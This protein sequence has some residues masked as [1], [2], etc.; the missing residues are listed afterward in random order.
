MDALTRRIH[1]D[2]ERAYFEVK[3]ILA[4]C[5]SQTKDEHLKA[6]FTELAKEA[7]K[8]IDEIR[9]NIIEV[10]KKEEKKEDAREENEENYSYLISRKDQ[11]EHLLEHAANASKRLSEVA[12]ARLTEVERL[13]FSH[14]AQEFSDAQKYHQLWATICVFAVSAGLALVGLIIYYKIKEISL[15]SRTIISNNILIFNAL[16]KLSFLLFCVWSI[17]YLMLLYF[18]HS[19]QAV[20]YRDRKIALTVAE[21]SYKLSETAE[22]KS[23]ILIKI[24]DSCFDLSKNLFN[25]V[26]EPYLLPSSKQISALSDAL[27]PIIELTKVS[28]SAETKGHKNKEDKDN[29]D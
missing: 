13:A 1:A 20:S 7:Y 10:D 25:N 2:A 22:E 5:Q 15:E 6:H 4:T 24:I 14:K 19:G 12:Q 11:L 28:A 3:R 17:R 23:K 27:K 18:T 29:A 8:A 21:A 9:I 26:K 16:G